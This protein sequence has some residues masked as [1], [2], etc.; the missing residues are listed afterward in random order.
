MEQTLEK[1]FLPWEGPLGWVFI[2]ERDDAKL[3][4]IEAAVVDGKYGVYLVWE[5]T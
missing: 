1:Q 4:R 3:V 2:P 5:V